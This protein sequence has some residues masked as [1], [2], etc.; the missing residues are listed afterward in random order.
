MDDLSRLRQAH[1]D[2]VVEVAELRSR[3][4]EFEAWYREGERIVFMPASKYF[5]FRLGEWWGRRPW[6]RHTWR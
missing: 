1:A 6:G 5:L 2:L 3:M 4:A